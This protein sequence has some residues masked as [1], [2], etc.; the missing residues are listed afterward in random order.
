MSCVYFYSH[1]LWN[2][3]KGAV[4]AD[5]RYA[6]D[7]F[8]FIFAKFTRDV[9]S[10]F[11]L[12]TSSTSFVHAN[13]NK[14]FAGFSLETSFW[15]AAGHF[16]SLR[17]RFDGECQERAQKI[18]FIGNSNN[19]MKSEN[20]TFHIFLRF[21]FWR[22]VQILMSWND[23]ETFK[24]PWK[25]EKIIQDLVSCRLAKA[26]NKQEWNPRRL[27]NSQSNGISGFCFC[28]CQPSR[29]IIY[30]WIE[31]MSSYWF[32]YINH[33]E[34]VWAKW[35]V[36]LSSSAKLWMI[37]L[38]WHLTVECWWCCK[39]CNYLLSLLLKTMMQGLGIFMETS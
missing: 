8:T 28:C 6:I 34:P 4:T 9:N 26:K 16:F 30:Y 10:V 37:K 19:E 18:N 11:Y 13:V 27:C 15:N 29:E 31:R 14:R 7:I 21:F 5:R 1:L 20:D 22:G 24:Y 33:A 17:Y 3:N 12:H 36:R 25:H 35:K 2:K 38:R 39:T 32:E 23:A